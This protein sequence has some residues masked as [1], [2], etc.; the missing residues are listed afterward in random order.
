MS[1][2]QVLTSLVKNLAFSRAKPYFLPYTINLKTNWA[3]H[4]ELTPVVCL[5]L[6]TTAKMMVEKIP[7]QV[8]LRQVEV[9][10]AIGRLKV[11]C[12]MPIEEGQAMKT[13]DEYLVDTLQSLAH[14]S[15]EN[16]D[17]ASLHH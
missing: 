9:R 5:Y 15:I 13:V 7:K 16:Q 3:K 6:K 12:G 10:E 2:T 14:I 8:I 1:R 11:E 17:W 4:A